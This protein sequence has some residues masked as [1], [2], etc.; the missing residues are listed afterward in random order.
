[1]ASLKRPLTAMHGTVLG[2]GGFKGEQETLLKGSVTTW[3]G[4]K[5]GWRLLFAQEPLETMPES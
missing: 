4:N 2:L 3:D 1:M 5:E